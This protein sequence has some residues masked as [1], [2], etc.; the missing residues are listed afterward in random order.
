MLPLTVLLI[1]RQRR[2]YYYEID[3]IVQGEIGPT[4]Q[5]KENVIVAGR[6][7]EGFEAV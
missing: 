3:Q 4:T 5:A 1:W 6:T 2:C 7:V